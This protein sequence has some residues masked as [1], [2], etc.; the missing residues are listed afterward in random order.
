[1][2][3][4][5]T[6][7]GYRV[8]ALPLENEKNGFRYLYAKRHRSK[9][10]DEESSG[11]RILF[12]ANVRG[13]RDRATETQRIERCDEIKDVFE[14]SIGKVESVTLSQLHGEKSLQDSKVWCAKISFRD[15]NA[16]NVL[17]PADETKKRKKKKKKKMKKQSPFVLNRGQSKKKQNNVCTELLVQHLKRYPDPEILKEETDRFVA[18]F[19]TREEQTRLAKE[20]KQNEVDEDGFIMVSRKRQVRSAVMEANENRQKKKRKKNRELKNFYQWQVR[21]A[22]RDQLKQL[23]DKFEEDKMR[24]AKLK[25]ARKFRPYG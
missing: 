1:M 19:E 11:N 8:L 23:R 16:L 3:T 15:E 9:D 2:A 25:A 10:V 20:R 18:A 6:L 17:F 14:T 24:I 13:L 5:L 4:T 7:K 22:K 21:E 12:V